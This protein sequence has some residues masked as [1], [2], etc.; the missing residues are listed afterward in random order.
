MRDPS[1]DVERQITAA[2]LRYC[3]G[4]DR[5]DA[6]LIRSAYH[7]DG[8]DDHGE[9]FRGTIDEYIPW[10]LGVLG[11]RFDSTMHTLSNISIAADGGVA[12]VESYL[13]AYHV[14]KGGGALRVFGARYVDRFE[15]R[16]AS[17]WRIAHRRLVSE[18]QTEQ[19]GQFVATPPG[20]APAARD[21]TD[22]SY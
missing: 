7:A 11:E 20:T 21:R 9:A 2:L 10:V 6:D 4:I 17:R 22:P 5:M 3:R 15:D 1:L 16:P 18:W 14:T 19:V 12:T 13:I 8:V